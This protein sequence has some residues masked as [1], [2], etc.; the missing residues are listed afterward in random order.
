MISSIYYYL[1][2]KKHLLECESYYVS[3]PKIEICSHANESPTGQVEGFPPL[4]VQGLGFS[5]SAGL[6]AI[7][8]H[9]WCDQPISEGTVTL[10]QKKH[11][12]FYFKA[13]RSQP[14]WVSALLPSLHWFLLSEEFLQCLK[15]PDFICSACSCCWEVLMFMLNVVIR[16]KLN[17]VS[18]R[19]YFICVN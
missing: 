3:Y 10:L 6:V 1:V 18:L 12:V 14:H 16:S 5:I 7:V 8:W 19:L 9:A 13:P 15:I 4:P 17:R 11:I 2:K